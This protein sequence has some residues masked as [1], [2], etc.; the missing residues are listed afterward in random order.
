MTVQKSA[1]EVAV[2]F[3]LQ[4]GRHF[5]ENSYCNCI[6]RLTEVIQW[7]RSVGATAERD[8]LAAEPKPALAKARRFSSREPTSQV[9]KAL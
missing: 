4:Q 7:E 6:D 9:R 3:M 8:R 5:C 2:E 1:R